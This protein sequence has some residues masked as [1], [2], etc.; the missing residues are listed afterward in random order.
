[1]IQNHALDRLFG[2]KGLAAGRRWFDPRLVPIRTCLVV[3]L[4]L[5]NA[6]GGNNSTDPCE[7]TGF[8]RGD[9]GHASPLDIGAGEARAGRI[10][11]EQLPPTALGLAVWAGGDFV[12][13]NEK[14]ALVIEDVGPSDLY[15]PWGG[16][17]VGVASVAGGALTQ[18]AD[19]GEFFVL[20]GRYTVVTQEVTVLNDG[21]DG[22]AAVV[23][24]AGF[25]APLPFFE[26][27]TGAILRDPFD[28]VF[29]AIDYVLEPGAD[30]VDIRVNY[31]SP[32]SNGNVVNVI[33]HGFM[34]AKRMRSFAPRIGFAAD[35]QLADYLGFIDEDATSYAYEVPG[36]QLGTGIAQSGFTSNINDGFDIPGCEVMTRDHARLII[37]GP[38]LDGLIQAVARTQNETLRS[39]SGVVRDSAGAPAPGVRV[40]A[41]TASGDYVTRALTGQ[42]GSYELHVASGSAVNLT[43]FRRGDTIV[44]PVSVETGTATADF[45]L[46][47]GGSVHI[48]AADAG[49][50]TPLPVRVQVLPSGASIAPTP[51]Q[52]FGELAI[53]GGRA[54]VEF[55]TNGDTTL[56]LPV[57]DWEV[58]VSRGYEYEIHREVISITE[59]ATVEVQADLERV[60][61]TTGLM[62][63]DFHIHTVRSADGAR[64]AL[65]MAASG[66]GDGLDVLARSD[67]EYIS[68]FEPAIAALGLET[69]AFGIASVEMTSLE[70]W[71]HMGVLPIEPVPGAVNAGT[72]K[73]Q[74]FPSAADPDVEL[75]LL[76]PRDVFAAVRQRPEGSRLIINH[77]TGS[78]NYF[79]YAGFNDE[80]G[81]PA[82][83]EVWD[84]Q[85]T[86]IEAFN[87]GSFVDNRNGS[88]KAWFALL[89]SGRPVSAVGS[90]DAHGL[91]GEGTGY[92]RT[93][94]R[95]GTDDPR[96]LTPNSVADATTQGRSIVSGGVYVSA[97]VSGASSGETVATG[98]DCHSRRFRSGRQLDRGRHGSRL[99]STESRLK[100][101][102]SVQPTP[103][104]SIRRFAI[105][106][107]DR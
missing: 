36:E 44:G 40:H 97:S 72:P 8:E 92:P 63:A 82:N 102:R 17:P 37:G 89:N 65:D 64:T 79:G 35:A 15:D 16:R 34:Y 5:A 81:I 100:P 106:R 86:T 45:D 30:H 104:Q 18:P 96:A 57:G 95:V 83:P 71:G 32:K 31:F 90:S 61:D 103:I 42:D 69:F 39:I 99:S 85:F 54:Q 101:S 14:I 13:A 74:R 47:P 33:M 21:S 12:L 1:M 51:P 19:F 87:G 7:F 80:T 28:G 6:C 88:V 56:R 2:D 29:A 24:A 84:E 41:E 94:L 73:W 26:S 11:A 53:V 55:P 78:L 60:V 20:T 70:T 3:A 58:V 27:I 105:R 75:E 4:V 107:S 38:G 25:L 22:A 77:P 66:I 76:N 91:S 9:N 50:G 93:C 49:A 10:L 52:N 67:H 48:V 59:G 62:C 46:L 68:N 23:R 98:T 43:A